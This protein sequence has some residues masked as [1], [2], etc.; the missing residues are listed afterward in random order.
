MSWFLVGEKKGTK[1]QVVVK[2]NIHWVVGFII[3]KTG[4]IYIGF[5]MVCPFE[6]Q[7]KH[8]HALGLRK[9][10]G[11]VSGIFVFVFTFKF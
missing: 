9:M 7:A 5:V 11:R 3:V 1:G 8:E 2:K 4:N 10:F 6:G